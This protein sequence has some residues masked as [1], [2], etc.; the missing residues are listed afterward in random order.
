MNNLAA[1]IE[2]AYM[3]RTGR[4]TPRGARTWFAR[5]AKVHKQSVRRWLSGERPFDGPALA[6]LELLEAG[7]SHS[8]AED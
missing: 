1:R 7:P 2:A 5:Q 6:V 3:R 4:S 8:D